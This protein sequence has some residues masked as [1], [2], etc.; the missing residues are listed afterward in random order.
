MTI[1]IAQQ[2]G[3]LNIN[4]KTSD[5]LGLHWT[6]LNQDKEALITI[7]NQ[8]SMTTGLNDANFTSTNPI[9]LTYLADAGTRWVYHNGPYITTRCCCK[10]Y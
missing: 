10:C 1:G 9:N 2:E 7:K 8:L 5:Y 4:D 3:F 6:A